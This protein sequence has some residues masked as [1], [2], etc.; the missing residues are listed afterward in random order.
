M[1]LF[2]FFHGDSLGEEGKKGYPP[3]HAEKWKNTLRARGVRSDP[4]SRQ[5]VDHSGPMLSRARNLINARSKPESLP[6]RFQLRT[7]ICD[8]TGGEKAGSICCG[9]RLQR[10]AKLPSCAVFC[11]IL[12]AS[13]TRRD[14]RWRGRGAAGSLVA[15]RVTSAGEVDGASTGARGRLS[16]RPLG[17][18]LAANRWEPEE[19]QHGID[20]CDGRAWSVAESGRWSYGVCQDGS[21]EHGH[22]ERD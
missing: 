11:P 19:G 2:P 20:R 12:C 22:G 7:G 10:A 14:G 13:E 5:P 9:D 3:L 18:G 6:S 16:G 21:P 4:N 15:V 1:T 8:I 17:G